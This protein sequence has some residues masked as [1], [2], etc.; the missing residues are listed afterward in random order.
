MIKRLKN[1]SMGIIIGVFFAF[2]S[3]AVAATESVQAYVSSVIMMINGS[4]KEVPA[5]YST[6]NYNGHVYVPIRFIAENLQSEVNYDEDLQLVSINQPEE[7]TVAIADNLKLI[8]FSQ[9]SQ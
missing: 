5:Q 2:G 7:K 8:L 6:L 3:S 9:K 4:L 1:V